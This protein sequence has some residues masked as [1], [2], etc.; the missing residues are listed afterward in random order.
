[1]IRRRK[2]GTTVITQII[3]QFN[4]TVL[5]KRYF[6]DGLDKAVERKR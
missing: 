5:K 4:K 3:V 1:M 2:T 6:L